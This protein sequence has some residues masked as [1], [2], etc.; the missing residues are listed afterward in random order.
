MPSNPGIVSSRQ[1]SEFELAPAKESVPGQELLL[2][3]Q[4]VEGEAGLP[5][6]RLRVG[7]SESP[8]RPSM[9]QIPGLR[10]PRASLARAIQMQRPGG[11]VE[12]SL[13]GK[14]FL[15]SQGGPQIQAVA[16]SELAG[17]SAR[18]EDR[19]PEGFGQIVHWDWRLQEGDRFYGLG[20]RS[21]PLERRGTACTNW[22]TDEPSGHH[23]TTDPLY[24]AHPLVWGERQG[25]WWAAFLV[26]S[27][28][29]RFDLGQ[30]CPDRMRWSSLGE[31]LEVL[32]AAGQSPAEVWASL[33]QLW[34]APSLPPLWA[35]GFHQSRWGYRSG[36]EIEQL[37]QEFRQRGLPLDAVHL[38]ID[39]MEGYRSFSFS[40]E[41]FPD[42]PGLI[43]RLGAEGVKT[44]TI[45]DPGLRFAPGSGYEPLEEG[46][47]EG[48]FLTSESGSPWVG[49]CWP[50]EALFP[51]FYRPE[52]RQWWGRWAATY[53]KSG[54]SGLWIDMNEP[55]IFDR[56][57]WSGGARQAPLP[58]SLRAGSEGQRFTQAALHNLYGSNMA[59]ATQEAWKGCEERPWILTRSGFAGVG[60]LA[61]SWMGD[62]TSWWEHLQMS[63]PQLASMG[64]SG[65]TFVGVDIG[66]FFAHCSAE[67]YSAWIE[68]AVVYPFFRAHSA[69]GTRE[70]HPWSFGPEVEAVARRALE[71][72]YRLLPY[73]YATAQGQTV[74][75]PPWLRPMF[76]DYPEDMRFVACE[77]QVMVGP[78]LMA[79]P[80]LVRGQQHRVVE[81]PTGNWYDFHSGEALE[82]G[83]PWLI[84]RRPGLIPL[85]ARAGSVIPLWHNQVP[86]DHSGQWAESNWV[87]QVFPGKG[88]SRLYW[89][90]G[91]GLGYQ[92]GQYLEVELA[93]EGDSVVP[94]TLHAW[95]GATP[96]QLAWRRPGQTQSEFRPWSEVLRL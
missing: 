64:L 84:R 63:F 75:H 72:R 49:Y 39:H 12:L 86:P 43:A 1:V 56:P 87:L 40:A 51:D 14:V 41:R 81:L 26:H 80:F 67:L 50:D 21:M 61:W 79:A 69:L 24:Q 28:Y 78:D 20:Q 53:L 8:H 52:T 23:R 7:D 4:A 37:V 70:Q 32:V 60:G 36:Q 11:D 93:V 13:A 3:A 58:L 25:I 47:A 85:F 83:R 76:F 6:L 71:L 48:H 46:L 62:N 31:S 33:Q 17:L 94:S 73:F 90:Q 92:Q 35:L 9:N 74:G 30:T 54:V 15:L 22:T 59:L 2:Q 42:A 65:S 5:L 34:E 18:S 82:G 38:D 45:L 29:T 19:L 88:R 77:D 89:D 44:V 68:A 57:F 10:V 27:S 95:E 66:G 91:Q 96:P 16:L 55:A